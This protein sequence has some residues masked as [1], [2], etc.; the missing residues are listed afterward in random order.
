MRVKGGGIALSV[1]RLP[2]RLSVFRKWNGMAGS[3]L[4][5]FTLAAFAVPRRQK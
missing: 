1:T 4:H 5:F 3:P 2:F